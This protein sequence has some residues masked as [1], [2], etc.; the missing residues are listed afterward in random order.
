MK[1][2]FATIPKMIGESFISFLRRDEGKKSRRMERKKE[3][4]LKKDAPHHDTLIMRM[5]MRNIRDE[6]WMVG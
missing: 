2:I 5:R 4:I 6:E 1:A 3:T